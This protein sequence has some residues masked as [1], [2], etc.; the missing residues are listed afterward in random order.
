[1]PALANIPFRWMIRELYE[2]DM[3]YSLNVHWRP[4]RLAHYGI[5]LPND[6]GDIVVPDTATPRDD[7]GQPPDVREFKPSDADVEI[8]NKHPLR[9]KFLQYQEFKSGVI[10]DLDFVEKDL[11]APAHDGMWK[12]DEFGGIISMLF[13]WVLELTPKITFVQNKHTGLWELRLRFNFFRPRCI[14]RGVTP[15]EDRGDPPDTWVQFLKARSKPHY[16]WSVRE[17]MKIKH[18]Y[19]P[20]PWGHNE[21]VDETWIEVY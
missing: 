1:M 5:L 8:Q 7:W 9:A 20:R 14:P 12:W 17:R 15:G 2:A 21:N 10:Y 19:H 18:G 16:H 11:A 13:W 4:V 6:G 3:R